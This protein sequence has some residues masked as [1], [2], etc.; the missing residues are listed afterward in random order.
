MVRLEGQTMTNN[1]GAVVAPKKDSSELKL[2]SQVGPAIAEQLVDQAR[3]DGVDLVG[4]MGCWVSSPNRCSR[5]VW[6]SR[7]MSILAMRNMLMRAE[8][9]RTA[10]TGQ[11]RKR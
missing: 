6:R 5:P 7:S 8:T 10:V 11:G 3:T 1:D 2:P 4:L 9:V